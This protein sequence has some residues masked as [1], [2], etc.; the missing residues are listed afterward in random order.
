[1]VALQERV[2]GVK[3]HIFTLVPAWFFSDSG[4]RD[5]EWHGVECDLGLVQQTT[6][7]ED[8]PAT[9]EKLK[10]FIPL[11]RR[12]GE[13]A[14]E[15]TLCECAIAI[16]DIAPMGILAA[17]MAGIPSVL[18]ENFTW[19]WIYEGYLDRWPELKIPADTF[20]REFARATYHVQTTPACRPSDCDLVTP[21]VSRKPRE[22]RQSVRRVLGVDDGTSMVLLTMGGIRERRFRVPEPKFGRRV[23][24]VIVGPSDRVERSGNVILLPHHS[25]LYHPDLVH[26]ADVVIGKLGY[27]TLAECY[28]AGVPFGYIARPSFREGGPLADFAQREM[29]GVAI[30]AESYLSGQ[31]TTELDRLLAQPRRSK[32]VLNG[33]D[34]A[35][36]FILRPSAR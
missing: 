8:V 4:V 1:M 36:E 26:A 13:L 32:P 33:A 3:L 11:D 25:E 10:G 30:A 16:C 12:A 2:P 29:Q 20:A 18:V 35:A 24:F 21:P 5:F 34:V 22:S 23:A 14:R 31:W 9:V 6:L 27:S 7:Q 17:H 19:D 28:A 15:L